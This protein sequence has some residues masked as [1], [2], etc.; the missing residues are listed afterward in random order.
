MT[1][2]WDREYNFFGWARLRSCRIGYGLWR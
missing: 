1:G 2:A